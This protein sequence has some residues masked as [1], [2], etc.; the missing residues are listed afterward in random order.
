MESANIQ[1]INNS[2]FSE[3]NNNNMCSEINCPQKIN[4]FFYCANIKSTKDVMYMS[5]TDISV[6]IFQCIISVF[7]KKFEIIMTYK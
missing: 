3:I 5:E 2:M 4:W 1:N 7:W 6:S